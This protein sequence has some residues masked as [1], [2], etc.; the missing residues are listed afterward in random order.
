MKSTSL[1]VAACLLFLPGITQA[2]NVRGIDIDFVAIG[3]PGNGA[4]TTGY[5]A[6]GHDYSIGTYEVTNAQWDAFVAAAGA[7][8]GLNGTYITG[9]QQPTTNVSWE[10][11][12]QFCNYLTSGDK[13]SGVYQ[14]SW[15]SIAP[16]PNS[17]TEQSIFYRRKMNGTRRPTITAAVIHSMPTDKIQSQPLTMAGIMPVVHTLLL[18][19]LVLAQQSRMERSI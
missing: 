8:A 14:F 6:V 1:L 4:D 10:E 17:P 18:G 11:A 3:N 19:M 2:V 9:A 7:P 13:S 15:A 5:G 16:Q 12:V